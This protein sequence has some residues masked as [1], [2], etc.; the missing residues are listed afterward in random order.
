MTDLLNLFASNLLP[1]I[2]VAAVGFAL[3]RLLA[4][5]PRP[6]AQTVFYVLS[7]ALVFN[8]LTSTEIA[9]NELARMA[10][11]AGLVILSGVGVSW[12]IG[13]IMKLESA[14][15]A[16]FVLSASFMNSGNYG[17]SLNKFALGEIGLAWASIFFITSALLINS[18][19]VYIAVVGRA[20]PKQAL[21]GLAKVPAV[22]VIP[23]AIL[24][25]ATGWALPVAMER[26]V[27]LLAGAAVPLMLIILGMQ[28]AKS[29]ALH[30][31]GLLAVTV[32][33]RLLFS[34]ILAWILVRPFELGQVA[35]QAAILEAAMPTAVFTT[36]IATK[37]EVDPDFATAAVFATT[38]LSP[39]SVTPLLALLR[40]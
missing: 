16:S 36:V 1:I 31:K 6:L 37:F 19:G 27:T 29:N 38:L 24:Q 3:Q 22:Y 40:G 26:S 10:G 9:L 17:L 18:L 23:I 15:L 8:L 5:D 12:V 7:P 30:Q 33:L 2:L 20:S 34:P 21:L 13:R 39:L 14:T 4:L 35:S 11:L 25:R 32:L 28:I